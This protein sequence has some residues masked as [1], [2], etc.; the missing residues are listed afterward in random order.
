MLPAERYD[1]VGVVGIVAFAFFFFFFFFFC[2]FWSSPLHNVVIRCPPP[3]WSQEHSDISLPTDSVIQQAEG[4]LGR[5]FVWTCRIRFVCHPQRLLI[6]LNTGSLFPRWFV[7]KC[8]FVRLSHL[9]FPLS[10]VPLFRIWVF[11]GTWLSYWYRHTQI[12][13]FKR[14]VSIERSLYCSE[15][16]HK[17]VFR[18]VLKWLPVYPLFHWFQ[19]YSPRCAVSLNTLR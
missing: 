11:V 2:F 17:V 10:Q 5:T 4:S 12:N 3:S 15:L 14:E 13:K 18:D 8:K 9:R 16:F 1:G 19:R 6:F 7:C